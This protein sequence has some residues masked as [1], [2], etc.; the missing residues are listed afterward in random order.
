MPITMP[1]PNAAGAK[2]ASVTPT[3]SQYYQA[4][5]AAAGPRWQTAVD[6]SQNNWAQGV[7]QAMTDN[8]YQTGVSGRGGVYATKAA[9]V[10]TGRWQTG[11]G[12]GATAYEQGVA[13]IFSALAGA[14]L[15][16][17]MAKGNPGNL[18]RVQAVVE[19]ERAARR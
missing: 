6:G 3:R 5:V 7:S 17:R 9:N 1:S 15:P 19:I 13:P 4:A 18:A 10:G 11:V 12:Q 14:N 8:R 16:P 2:W